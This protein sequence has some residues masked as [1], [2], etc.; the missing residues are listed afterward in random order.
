MDSA[1][2]EVRV[3]P[4]LLPLARFIGDSL[5]SRRVSP[6]ALAKASGL[7]KSTVYS[8]LN[9]SQE[10][11]T[12]TLEKLAA[13]LSKVTGENISTVTLRNL[14]RTSED[15]DPSSASSCITPKMQ[16]RYSE[17]TLLELIRVAP[18]SGVMNAIVVGV[19]RL[20]QSGLVGDISGV[21][22]PKSSLGE[23]M[24]VHQQKEEKV[25]SDVPP[26]LPQVPSLIS[27]ILL[28]LIE[29]NGLNR[30]EIAQ[31]LSVPAS[32]VDALITQRTPISPDEY[33]AIAAL[34]NQHLNEGE[35]EWTAKKLKATKEEWDRL[36]G[37]VSNGNGVS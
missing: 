5:S 24:A 2:V 19:E 4:R 35:E 6:V 20:Q 9:A 7:G 23:T 34:I 11:M 37:K 17:E 8:I 28:Q 32:R 13:G 10:P 3:N 1:A 27:S 15:C 29:V 16:V 30:G 26:D 31:A 21:D 25:M 33:A 18:L 36:A 12:Q 14:I 22:L